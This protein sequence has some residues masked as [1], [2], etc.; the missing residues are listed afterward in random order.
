MVASYNHTILLDGIINVGPLF[1]ST[2]FLFL[3]GRIEWRMY[4][5]CSLTRLKGQ[6]HGSRVNE[7]FRCLGRLGILSL[8]RVS[9][10]RHSGCYEWCYE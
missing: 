5:A 9:A 3:W 4:S 2:V 7:L 1:D 8:L 6:E 10:W